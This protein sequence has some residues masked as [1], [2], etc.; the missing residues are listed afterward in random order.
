LKT[1]FSGKFIVL[2]GPDGCGKTTQARLLVEWLQKQKVPTVRFHERAACQ[3]VEHER[4]SQVYKSI[5]LGLTLL[6]DV[7]NE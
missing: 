3:A 6:P 5:N 1:K 7:S 2:D 4:I